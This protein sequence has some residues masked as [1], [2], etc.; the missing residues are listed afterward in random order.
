VS[1]RWW[2]AIYGKQ[3]RRY[4]GMGPCLLVLPFWRYAWFLSRAALL[5]S[6]N[7][8]VEDYV[9]MISSLAPV[10]GKMIKYEGKVIENNLFTDVQ[11]S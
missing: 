1:T 3:R 11:S 8:N 9:N 6:E 5:E 7:I 2:I 10:T 4:I